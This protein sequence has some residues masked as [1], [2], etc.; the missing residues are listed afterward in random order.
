MNKIIDI[1]IRSFK[2]FPIMDLL[3]QIIHVNHTTNVLRCIKM[4]FWNFESIKLLQLLQ[5]ICD[6]LIPYYSKNSADK[7][8]MRYRI[9]Y[10]INLTA[11]AEVKLIV[12]N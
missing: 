3:Q 7:S 1:I 4:K 11:D 5:I 8:L 2:S 6:D 9:H 10:L 12:N